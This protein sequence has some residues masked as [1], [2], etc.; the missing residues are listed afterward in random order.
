M[1]SYSGI[2]HLWEVTN[3]LHDGLECG[4][5]GL[6]VSQTCD[7]LDWSVERRL[8]FGVH[9]GRTGRSVEYSGKCHR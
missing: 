4:I 9:A 3:L 2:L 8:L 6:R 7:V 1:V 5:C